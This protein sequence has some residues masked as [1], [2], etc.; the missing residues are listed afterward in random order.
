MLELLKKIGVPATVAAVIATLVTITPFIFKIDER[1][2]KQD[3]LEAQAARNEK[4]INELTVEIG[5]LSGTQE[6]LVTMMAAQEAR[7]ASKREPVL[8]LNN[9]P[10]SNAGG[11]VVAPAPKV[12]QAPAPVQETKKLEAVKEELRSQQLRV[13]SL[14]Y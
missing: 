7:R 2:A 6:V 10:A 4:I 5:K 13:Q 11:P 8:D 3:D 9:L 1:Y 14:K 12:V